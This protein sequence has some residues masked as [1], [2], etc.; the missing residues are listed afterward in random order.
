MNPK[1]GKG[2]KNTQD[3][4]GKDRQ[5]SPPS[6][7]TPLQTKR[8]RSDHGWQPELTQPKGRGRTAMAAFPDP[9]EEGDPQWPLS[10]LKTNKKG[11]QYAKLVLK[12]GT[13]K[14]GAPPWPLSQTKEMKGR[15]KHRKVYLRGGHIDSEERKRR[16]LKRGRTAM[17]AFPDQVGEPA[18]QE[19]IEEPTKR[20]MKRGR[21]AMA[22]FP[23]QVGR[24][25]VKEQETTDRDL[26]RGR[27][28]RAAFPDQVGGLAEEK[29]R[30]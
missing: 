26:K 29:N 7:Q 4:K 14:G 20:D 16:D 9:K 27:T 3:G 5:S 17:A 30:Q 18:K 1:G 22:A 13:R 19:N 10:P 12:G 15:S 8:I 23:N 6:R 25:A 2:G 11:T 28:A 21:T 24:L